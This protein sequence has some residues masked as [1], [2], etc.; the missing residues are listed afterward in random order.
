MLT[1]VLSLIIIALLA[2]VAYLVRTNRALRRRLSQLPPSSPQPAPAVS[3]QTIPAPAVSPQ[4]IPAPAVSPQPI[5]A[6][7]VSPQ[8]IPASAVSPQPIPTPAVSPQA[9]P[10]PSPQAAPLPQQV[11][12][13]AEEFAAIDRRVDEQ[14]LFLDATF[15]REGLCAASGLSKERIGQLIRRFG[16][17]GNVQTYLNRKRVAYAL[18]L[19][20]QHPHY[21]MEAVAEECGI[22]NPSTFYRVFKQVYGTS[23]NE[24]RKIRRNDQQT[25]TKG[26]E[27]TDLSV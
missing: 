5:P 20:Q 11:L 8:A 17:G 18:T 19:M 24:Y 25:P 21:S 2:A 26:Q 6:P 23:P 1:T 3:P 13:P 27:N 9:S 22:G 10:L 7:A 4:T 16:G 12:T 15:G 14:R